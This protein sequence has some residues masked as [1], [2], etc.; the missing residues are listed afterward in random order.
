[1]PRYIDAELLT[2][3]IAQIAKACAKSDKQKALV[4]RILFMIEHM[5]TIEA[6]PVNEMSECVEKEEVLKQIDCWLMTGEYKY[7]NATHYLNKRILSIKPKS[8]WISVKD[9]LPENDGLY[10][11]CKTV[12]GHRIS[13]EAHW[14][15]NKWLSV[16]KNNQLDYVTHWQHLPEPPKEDD[17]E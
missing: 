16:V 14:K 15:E 10:I 13:F 3:N 8:D 9:R 1:M 4:G 7:S 12:R 2:T 5:P 17:A 6:E 11:V